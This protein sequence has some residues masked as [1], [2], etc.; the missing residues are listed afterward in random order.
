M[1]DRFIDPT[2][3]PGPRK[4]APPHASPTA[5]VPLV[6]LGKDQVG[7]EIGKEPVHTLQILEFRDR[8]LLLAH[9]IKHLLDHSPRQTTFGDVEAIDV[10]QFAM[11]VR[12]AGNDNSRLGTN[13]VVVNMAT[14]GLDNI[15]TA[16]ASVPTGQLPE[17]GA[18]ALARA[19]G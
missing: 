18:F 6:G 12:D 9:A 10:L 15:C 19:A 8:T 16:G 14:P 17:A 1:I 13:Q 3:S 4:S 2:H 11:A 7:I 5:G